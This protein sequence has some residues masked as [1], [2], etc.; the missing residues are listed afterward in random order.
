LCRHFNSWWNLAKRVCFLACF[1]SEC[2]LLPIY[3]ALRC[4]G[5]V[6]DVD[7]LKFEVGWN[8]F[9]H[10]RL[11]I[12]LLHRRLNFSIWIPHVLLRQ[13]EAFTAVLSWTVARRCKLRINHLLVL[14]QECHSPRAGWS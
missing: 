3:L 9:R 10:R 5:V 2:S 4:H 7:G 1:A 11:R 6:P 8:R 13:L 12:L 14:H